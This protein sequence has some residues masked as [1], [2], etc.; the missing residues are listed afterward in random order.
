[1]FYHFWD[2]KKIEDVDQV[3]F[4]HDKAPCFKAMQTQEMLTNSG[5]DFFDNTVWPGG[6]PDLND[7]ENIKAILK[8]KVDA[9]LHRNPNRFKKEMASVALTK[10]L[11]DMKNDQ[12][13]FENLLNNLPRRLRAEMS[14]TFVLLLEIKNTSHL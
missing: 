2:A 5:I 6:S 3:T 1:M 7:C 9:L 10:I 11:N 8:D 13:L 14:N 4:L 12:K